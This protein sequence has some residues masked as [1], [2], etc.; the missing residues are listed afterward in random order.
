MLPRYP[1]DPAT[2]RENPCR[3]RR[4]ASANCGMGEFAFKERPFPRL[5]RLKATVSRER[6]CLLPWHTHGR[7]P[8]RVPIRGEQQRGVGSGPLVLGQSA[9]GEF[10]SAYSKDQRR[11]GKDLPVQG[12]AVARFAEEHHAVLLPGPPNHHVRRARE[13]VGRKNLPRN[14]SCPSPLRQLPQEVNGERFAGVKLRC[15]SIRRVFWLV[16][17]RECFL[18]IRKQQD[19]LCKTHLQLR[20]EPK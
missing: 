9:H 13:N 5:H 4:Q 11:L 8:S 3:M 12:S 14:C 6:A 18:A 17:G 15:S 19:G 16:E 1:P 7:P 2:N 10:R 20:F